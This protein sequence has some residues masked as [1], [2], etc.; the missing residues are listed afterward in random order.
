MLTNG[1]ISEHRIFSDF[2]A[3]DYRKQQFSYIYRSLDFPCNERI[4]AD[5]LS[6]SLALILYYHHLT[7]LIYDF[8]WMLLL[9]FL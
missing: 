4:F 7:L 3:S 1:A 6:D 8:H 2:P 5:D 9:S